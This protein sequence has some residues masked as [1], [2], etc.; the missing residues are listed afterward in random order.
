MGFDVLVTQN[1]R[2][3]LEALRAQNFPHPRCARLD[4]ALSRWHRSVP[5]GAGDRQACLHFIAHRAQQQRAVIE[6]LQAGADDYLTK[7]FNQKNC[8]RV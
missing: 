1:G 4:D 3:A 7:P 2:E 6:E 8:A 5:A